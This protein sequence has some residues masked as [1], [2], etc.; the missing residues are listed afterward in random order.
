MRRVLSVRCK[1]IPEPGSRAEMGGS[2]WGESPPG[3]A[4]RRVTFGGTRK[5]TKRS[6]FK[7][8]R[9]FDRASE[10]QAATTPPELRLQT[11]SACT[12]P[13][14]PPQLRGTGAPAVPPN[15]PTNT[16]RAGAG[17]ALLAFWYLPQPYPPTVRCTRFA[18]A[19]SK[20]GWPFGICHDCRSRASQPRWHARHCAR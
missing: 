1:A 8:E 11:R 14:V 6:A 18:A 13:C 2:H 20:R 16:L 9:T 7:G 4:R 12:E 15:S 10:P 3:A 19:Q 5:V 17:Q